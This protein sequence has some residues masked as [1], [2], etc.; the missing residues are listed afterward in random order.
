MSLVSQ[1]KTQSEKTSTDRI[2][3]IFN[4]IYSQN[5]YMIRTESPYHED[6]ICEKS[7]GT[8]E[9]LIYLSNY[10]YNYSII[11]DFHLRISTKYSDKDILAAAEKYKDQETKQRLLNI[12]KAILSLRI[13]MRFVNTKAFLS[14]LH[15]ESHYDTIKEHIHHI[16]KDCLYKFT[17]QQAWDNTFIRRLAIM[18]V[19]TS[20]YKMALTGPEP[21]PIESVINALL[22]KEDKPDDI[23]NQLNHLKEY[24]IFFFKKLKID[25]YL[26]E[27]YPEIKIEDCPF[28]G[29][30]TIPWEYVTFHNGYFL[31]DH[32][33]FYIS[34]GSKYAYKYNCGQS[35]TAFNYI[36]KAFISKLPP[37]I[38]ECQR[39]QIMKV[40]NIGDIS[41]CVTALETGALP[42]KVKIQIPK[43]RT[44][45]ESL[46]FEEYSQ[47]KNDYKSIYLD[48]LAENLCEGSSIYYC[49]ECRLNSNNATSYEDA[50]IF[51]LTDNVLMY[52]NV[53]DKRAS[54]VFKI[55]PSKEEECTE[56]INSY[57]SSDIIVNKREKIASEMTLFLD[58]CIK[59]YKRIY[60][61]S[62]HEWK[63]ELISFIKYY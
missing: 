28:D 53:L 9:K 50:F 8:A 46:S 16:N 36:K 18:Y 59:D 52:E 29:I 19:I 54:V 44:T 14:I 31:I 61:T 23:I 40:I 38:V 56:A 57:F 10:A 17:K 7:I 55:D 60:H 47:R 15:L 22:Q 25:I 34:G 24:I 12:Y 58:S 43:Q 30:V 4:R 3:E 2:R 63:A 48:Y 51:R 62:F 1:M 33:R 39:G 6:L 42:P 32:P 37:I 20:Y 11:R 5:R 49:K 27:M 35:K 41:I 13:D 26:P 21:K 45:R